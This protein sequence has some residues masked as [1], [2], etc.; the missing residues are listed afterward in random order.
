MVEALMNWQG[1]IRQPVNRTQKEETPRCERHASPGVDELQWNH[2][3][4][5]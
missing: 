2:E 3:T 1:M 4:N 5:I